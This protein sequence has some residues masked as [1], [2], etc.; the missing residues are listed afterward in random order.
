M[1]S[2]IPIIFGLLFMAF[3]Y[4]FYSKKIA[5]LW[6]VK[7]NTEVPS[8]TMADGVDYVPAKHWLILFGHHFASIAGAGPI[9]GPVIAAIAWGWGPA[10][11]WIIFGSVLLGGVHDFSALIVSIR[12][13]GHSVGEISE[14]VLSKDIKIYFSLFLWFALILIVAVFAAVTAKTFISDPHVVIP[15]FGLIVVAIITGVLIYKLKLNFIISTII[16]LAFLVLNLYWG[17][18]MPIILPKTIE[19]IGINFTSLQVW[20]MILLVYAYIASILPVNILLQP[21]DYLSTYI[22]FFILIVGYLGV[23]IS[24][25]TIHTP[26]FIKFN[27][28]SGLMW[29]M[30]FVIIACGAISGFHSLIASGTTSKQITNTKYARR[31]GYGAMIMEGVLGLLALFA[32]SAGL[33]YA[34]Y[35]H[36]MKSSGWISTFATG[37]MEM[38]KSMF[39]RNFGYL[40]AIVA[41]N[42]F[43]ATT[44]DSATRINRYITEELFMDLFK[45]KLNRYIST[46][47][48]VLIAGVF[49]FGSWQKIW[50]VFGAANQLVAALVLLVVSMILIIKKRQYLY[51]LIP[52]FFM[53]LT[54]MFA[55]VLEAFMFFKQGAS[56]IILGVIAIILLILSFIFL[57]KIIK[58]LI[59]GKY[60]KKRIAPTQG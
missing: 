43:V 1:N 40:I 42:S 35:G 18:K 16:G 3:G 30:L 60:G 37:Y 22:L 52:A 25:P 32:V 56:G 11:F 39:G 28:S 10:F 26:F 47:L 38:V 33:K 57:I 53:I 34:Q 24:H 15:T 50:P 19:I 51:T 4:V 46:A 49:A 20:I 2:L 8:K 9:L 45:K 12:R 14:E 36:L 7:D 59:G 13:K 55:L 27:S 48:V 31:I 23:F 29:P 5:K 58:M 44:L 21:R 6:E 41:I 17:Y 54:T